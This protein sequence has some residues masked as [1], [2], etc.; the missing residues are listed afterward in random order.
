[1]GIVY[2]AR[3][4]GLNRLVALKLILAGEHAGTNARAR[5]RAEAEAVARL[6]HPNVVQIYEVGEHDS[7]PF[8]SLE[9]C[10]G[11]SLDKKL[12]EGPLPPDHAAALI[13]A[14]AEAVQAAH[15]A[16]VVHR[17]LKPA[18]VLLHATGTPKISD[19]GVAKRLG[20]SRRTAT[21]AILGTPTYMAPEQADAKHETVGPLTDVYALGTILYECLT[22]QPPFKTR[23]PL[24]T[25][26]QVITEDPSPPRHLNPK[27]P[28]DLQTICLKCLE[29]DP[30]RRYPSAQALG[31]DLRAY[32]RG[33]AI[34]ARPPGIVGRMN[35][36][37]KSQPTLAATLIGLTA[38]YLKHLVLLA[39]DAPNE[40]GASHW[41]ITGLTLAWASGAVGLQWI[42]TRSRWSVDATFGWAAL[43]VLMVTLMLELP[44]GPNSVFLI[45]YPLLIVGSTLR[46]R[47]SLL[48]FVTGL[49]IAGY[50]G[51]VIEAAWHRPYLAVG[52]KSWLAFTLG[53]LILAFVQHQVLR[54]LRAAMPTIH[55]P[56]LSSSGVDLSNLSVQAA[57]EAY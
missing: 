54:R 36:W 45:G 1:M 7:L 43:T 18:N 34:S 40:G 25:I 22:G 26:R 13:R 37:V 23:H 56:I 17:D 10:P 4:A 2:K 16:G 52:I 35:R 21:G 9:Y 42:V 27:I 53:L 57:A 41:F 46:L 44:K 12:A 48:W 49:C 15:T 24:A 51:I 47:T 32:E 50:L 31:D 30:R 5:F 38:F 3:Q 20:E 28:K 6:Q 29:K 11:G 55:E 19:F 8:I 33:E 39:L 14:L